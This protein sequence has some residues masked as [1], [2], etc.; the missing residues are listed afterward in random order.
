MKKKEDQSG[1]KRLKQRIKS[2][3]QEKDLLLDKLL[4]NVIT[5]AVYMKKEKELEERENS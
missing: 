3:E 1:R 2:I 5:D 4:K